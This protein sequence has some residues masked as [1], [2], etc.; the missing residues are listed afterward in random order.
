MSTCTECGEWGSK[1]LET[2]KQNN[3]WLSRRRRCKC[4]NVWWTYEIP[5]ADVTETPKDEEKEE[6]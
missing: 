2:R 4:G 1:V 5:A 3:G 6:E